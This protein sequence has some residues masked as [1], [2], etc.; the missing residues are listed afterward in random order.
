LDAIFV[1]ITVW[2]LKHFFKFSKD[3]YKNFKNNHGN[4][5]SIE[6]M[7]EFDD[8]SIKDYISLASSPYRGNV[9]SYQGSRDN[10]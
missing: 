1:L 7:I 4:G 10:L 3:K 2:S 9:I 6:E 8:S 5:K